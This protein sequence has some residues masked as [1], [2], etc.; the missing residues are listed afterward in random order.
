MKK[1][2]CACSLLTLLA[3]SAGCVSESRPEKIPLATSEPMVRPVSGGTARYVSPGEVISGDASAATMYDLDSAAQSLLAKM[4]KSALFTRQYQKVRAAKGD[5]LPV[6][7]LGNIDN[8]TT[9]RIQDR[10]DSVRDMV[11][12]SL[13]ES[14]LFVVKDDQAAATIAA[15]ILQSE[16]GGL[17]NGAALSALGEHESP[18]FLVLGDF[19]A[20]ADAGGFYTYRLRL[21]VHSLATGAVVW[22]GV[23]TK[24]KL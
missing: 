7:V 18:D 14:D 4:R 11:R 19:R 17:E 9:C 5:D 22:E 23:E 13:F 10:L 16:A 2:K 6:I 24:I 15:R 12:A 21:A 1:T 20:F 8:R 3:L